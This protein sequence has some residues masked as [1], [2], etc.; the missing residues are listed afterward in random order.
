M[1]YEFNLRITVDC[2]DRLEKVL[3]ALTGRSNTHAVQQSDGIIAGEVSMSEG[4]VAAD[5]PAA[6]RKTRRTAAKKVEETTEETVK[7]EAGNKATGWEPAPADDTHEM[8]AEE[9]PSLGKIRME[10][11]RPAMAKLWSSGNKEMTAQILAKHGAKLLKDVKP[12]EYR[13]L[14]NEF[15]EALHATS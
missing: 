13:T 14:L 8:R 9:A 5:A 1:N 10:D 4:T 7:I 15:N 11:L 2:T 12:E 6:P 3:T